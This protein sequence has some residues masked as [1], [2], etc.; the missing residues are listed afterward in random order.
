MRSMGTP[1]TETPIRKPYGPMSPEEAHELA[2][3]LL[4]PLRGTLKG[5]VQSYGGTE[6]YLRWVR[7][8]DEE[9]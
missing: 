8:E 6:G 1:L 9:D 7:G 5:V 2:E 3:R 4:A